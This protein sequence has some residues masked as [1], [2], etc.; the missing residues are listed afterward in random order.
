MTVEKIIP[1]TDDQFDRLHDDKRAIDMVGTV[2]AAAIAK[3]SEEAAR[4]ERLFWGSVHRLA[5]IVYRDA[6]TKVEVDWFNRCI[7]VKEETD[8]REPGE[9]DSDEIKRALMEV[10]RRKANSD[11]ERPEVVDL[12]EDR[13]KDDEDV[14]TDE[15]IQG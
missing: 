2:I 5:G 10:N 13:D 9:W 7:V 15:D 3:A 11:E 4:N 8:K 6:G 14:V 12:T 1:L